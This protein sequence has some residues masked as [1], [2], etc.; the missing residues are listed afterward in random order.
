M[1]TRSPTAKTGSSADMARLFVSAVLVGIGGAAV[2][3]LG[4]LGFMTAMGSLSGQSVV[5]AVQDIDVG[6]TLTPEHVEL[7][8]LPS[9]S[10]P[11]TFSKVST[12]LG[13]SV[14]SKVYAGDP[15]RAERL[16]PRGHSGNLTSMVPSGKRAVWIPLEGSMGGLGIEPGD[17]VD[18]W[19]SF[20]TQRGE[21]QT[22]SAAELL[23]V[24]YVEPATT[25]TDGRITLA[26][27]Q[28]QL[29]QI[30]QYR[31]DAQMHL[32][33][34]SDQEN[35]PQTTGLVVLPHATGDQREVH[36]ARDLL[37]GLPIQAEDLILR[38]RTRLGAPG[39]TDASAMEGRV[40]HSHILAGERLITARIAEPEVGRG[41]A[42]LIAP[43]QALVSVSVG[44]Q[45]EAFQI[46]GWITPML[47]IPGRRMTRLTD[48]LQ[49]MGHSQL[50]KSCPC[51]QLAVEANTV[52]NLVHAM[53]M[54]RLALSLPE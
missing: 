34:R 47:S 19:A 21:I 37:P 51:V 29:A 9:P 32:S 53:S 46:G 43:G 13:Y 11:Q 7:K 45:I 6:E 50:G 35:P 48:D 42:A 31:S 1:A 24:A 2:L 12:V 18:V 28:D 36:A 17:R 54:E 52:G 38:T 14:R 33:L 8:I 20:A 3:V 26:A 5:V 39:F 40:P 44:D 4:W 23:E 16:G 30:T 22:V 25:R 49:V 41:M 15:I 10:L 27:S